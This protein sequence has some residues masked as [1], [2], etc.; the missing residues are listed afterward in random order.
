MGNGS[1]EDNINSKPHEKSS[2]FAYPLMG[3]LAQF[4][5][6]LTDIEYLDINIMSLWHW[7]LYDLDIFY[8]FFSAL[9]PVDKGL[10]S[11]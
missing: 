3:N 6:V 2:G 7:Y 11:L 4:M 5:L 10:F 9:P 8:G 1:L